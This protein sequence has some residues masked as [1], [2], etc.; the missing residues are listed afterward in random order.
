MSG[1]HLG[2]MRGT[3]HLFVFRIMLIVEVRFQREFRTTNH[4]FET[5]VVVERE[6]LQR[7]DAVN[8]VDGLAT[9]EADTFVEVGSAV[10]F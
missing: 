4:T 10:E 6:V 8:L 3:I 7:A 9:A 5:P 1:S 2:H